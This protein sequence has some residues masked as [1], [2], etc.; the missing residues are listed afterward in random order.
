[1]EK[2]LDHSNI[3]EKV[4]QVQMLIDNLSSSELNEENNT[5]HSKLEEIDSEFLTIR[6]E[7]EEKCKSRNNLPWSPS[8]K[9]AYHDKHFWSLWI[10]QIKSNKQRNFHETRQRYITKT[11]EPWASTK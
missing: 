11:T 6:L 2:A 5:I 4:K 1:M 3:E 10:S 8:L 7:C 9:N